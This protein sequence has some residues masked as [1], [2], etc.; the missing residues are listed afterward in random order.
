VPVS[1]FDVP[2][3][4]DGLPGLG[5]GGILVLDDTVSAGELAAHLH[6]FAASESC[7]A[8][9]PCRIGTRML[10]HLHDRFA[11]ER[12]LETLELGSLCGFGQGVPRPLHD[13]LAHFPDELFARRPS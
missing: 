6:A 11:L 10:A 5:H 8:C 12:L 4:F 9:A 3:S 2:L 13:L 1:D 7:G